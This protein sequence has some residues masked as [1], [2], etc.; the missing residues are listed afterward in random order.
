MSITL[1]TETETVLKELR[2]LQEQLSAHYRKYAKYENVLLRQSSPRARTKSYYYL[3]RKGVKGRKYLG[4]EANA[5]VSAIKE[6]RYCREL[7]DIVAKDIQLLENLGTE[8]VLPV[9]DVIDAR[10][11]QVYQRPNTVQPR[12][13]SGKAEE[14]KARKEAEKARFEPYR[15]EDLVHIALDGTP[16][17]SHSE[18]LIAN[19]LIS[20]GI[21]YVYEMPISYKGK[22]KWPDFTILSPIDNR[23]EIIIEH[24]GAMNDAKYQDKFL[25]TLM[26]Y[27][28]TPLVPNKDV[29]FTFNHLDGNLD[30]R[31]IDCILRIAF[32]IEPGKRQTLHYAKSA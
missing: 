11:P 1:L 32:G 18:V 29:F 4:T 13:G 5:T 31:Q 15:P 10:L 26:F 2:Q 28:E 19:Y 20:L 30:L 6:A 9:H 3:S 27:L 14:W 22:R 7:Q 23:T 17:R 24:Q 21:T 12:T 25:R 16:M 8:Y